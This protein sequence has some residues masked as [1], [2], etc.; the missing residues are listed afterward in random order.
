MAPKRLSTS[1]PPFSFVDTLK[2]KTKEDF[3]IVI[4]RYDEDISWSNNYQEFRTVY[5]KGEPVDYPCIQLENIGHLADTILR[6]IINNYD[7]LATVTFF[8]HGSF[9]YRQDQTIKESGRCRKLFKEFISTNPDQLVYISKKNLSISTHRFYGY[10][11]T[12]GQVYSRFFDKQYKKGFDWACGKWISVG[13]KYIHN[14][15]KE[16]YQKMLDWVLSDYNGEQPSQGIYRTRGIY[17]E[18]LLLHGL[19]TR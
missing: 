17:I 15:P 12:I 5:N 4:A 16:F 19:K 3:E 1:T 10:P 8:T 9:N 2:D 7:N 14:R 6:H 13:K 18:R 11:E